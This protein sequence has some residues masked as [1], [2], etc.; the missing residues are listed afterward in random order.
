MNDTPR[1]KRTY[2]R[3]T[4][5]RNALLGKR[6][7][8]NKSREAYPER[9]P[10]DK[11]SAPLITEGPDAE[12][13]HAILD[14][15]G[16][17]GD[18]AFGAG[19]VFDAANA[20]WY[21][22]EALDYYSEFEKTGYSAI[23]LLGLLGK[24]KLG[25]ADPSE[26]D[27]LKHILK[28]SSGLL[29]NAL[30]AALYS[31]LSGI[32]IFPGIGDLAGKSLKYTVGSLNLKAK[33]ISRATALL[34]RHEKKLGKVVDAMVDKRM[35]SDAE[36]LKFI[37]ILDEAK[38]V[39][40]LE[41]KNPHI[42]R[43][44][45]NAASGS[46]KFA[47]GA[48]KFVPDAAKATREFAQGVTLGSAFKRGLGV[49]GDI[50]KYKKLT[51]QA[52]EL[53]D[54]EKNDTL[55]DILDQSLEPAD[56]DSAD[57]DSADKDSII[58]KLVN[59]FAGDGLDIDSLIKM[60]S[61]D[62]IIS[63]I[64]Q[65]LLAIF[66]ISGA[67]IGNLFSSAF[68]SIPDAPAILKKYNSPSIYPGG[69]AILAG[70]SQ[71]AGGIGRVLESELSSRGTTVIG[72]PGSSLARPGRSIGQMANDSNFFETLEKAQ[73]QV[74]N[75]D[76]QLTEAVKA[77]RPLSVVLNLGGNGSTSG[78][79]S[80]V[81]KI[82]KIAPKARI[83]FLGPPPPVESKSGSKKY[84]RLFEQRQEKNR[85]L[86]NQLSGF[87]Y[88]KFVDP[89]DYVLPYYKK[90]GDGLHMPTPIAKKYISDV[91]SNMPPRMSDPA[92]VQRLLSKHDKRFSQSTRSD[93]KLTASLSGEQLENS[94]IIYDSLT[95]RGFSD[96]IAK[97]AIVNAYAESGL[98]SSAVGDSGNSVGLF[99][100]HRNGAATL[101]S[102][103]NP[104]LAN[105]FNK[106]RE[107][108]KKIR[109]GKY[110]KS[111]AAA[112]L[113]SGDIRFSPEQNTAIIAKELQSGFGRRFQNELQGVD[114]IPTAAALF[115]KHIER[116][117]DK[118]L[119]MKKSY[120]LAKKMFP[121]A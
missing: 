11:L 41:L 63:T 103:N 30:E 20:V 74:G 15:L 17:G 14:V 106:T 39:A 64:G 114:D 102:K 22:K 110:N 120:Q 4:K 84:L 109:P 93:L 24:A 71:M 80:L 6:K 31:A 35:I 29:S 16:F 52:G 69:V 46:F 111:F 72:G 82:H 10:V 58:E 8:S 112:R 89:Y 32:S 90:G 60:I 91:L 7:A 68:K 108:Y 77:S 105:E 53:V 3:D 95:S 33:F 12:V 43:R 85:R 50:G 83:I 73:Q 99:Q 1:H 26:E 44:M 67:L 40:E 75:T 59:K 37:K 57:K 2:K 38:D 45:Y 21:A 86:E 19:A 97:A 117:K 116:P 98:R 87:T 47:Q 54:P 78:A 101:V 107:L 34:G 49:A 118:E 18:V 25:V 65:V 119:A 79:A 81:R 115:S 61:S 5:N 88:V 51:S 36:G 56:K 27:E 48:A 113:N 70:D 9:R 23:S 96:L 104:K 94:R 76:Q 100:V 121:T 13:G 42:V 62:D 28:H 66:A 55:K 92:S